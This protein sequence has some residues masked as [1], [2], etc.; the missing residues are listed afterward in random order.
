VRTST[1]ITQQA[2]V[3]LGLTAIAAHW[4]NTCSSYLPGTSACRLLQC[5]QQL[6][7]SALTLVAILPTFAPRCC[8]LMLSYNRS[9]SHHSIRWLPC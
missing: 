3:Q 1:L 7:L 9:C 5:L 2:I 8:C 6:L 4:L